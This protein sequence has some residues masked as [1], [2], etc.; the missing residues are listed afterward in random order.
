MS[1]L[2]VILLGLFFKGR[3]LILI[4][5]AFTVACAVGTVVSYG[6]GPP[7]LDQIRGK[8]DKT[9][10]TLT[11]EH[12]VIGRAASIGAVLAGIVGFQG[13]LRNATDDDDPSPWLV[14]SLAALQII[15]AGL[16]AW[17]AH[18]GGGIRHPE[19]RSQ[20]ITDT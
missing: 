6:S 19:A 9:T 5:F 10:V 3:R 4:G 18:L 17:T 13:L 15:V 20:S 2:A 11:E 14:R 8:L 1:T 12:A 16:T 7:A